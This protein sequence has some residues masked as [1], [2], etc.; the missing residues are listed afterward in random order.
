MPGIA[1]MLISLGLAAFCRRRNHH[2]YGG[3]KDDSSNQWDQNHHDRFWNFHWNLTGFL[4]YEDFVKGISKWLKTLSYISSALSRVYAFT[5]RCAT[6]QSI[7]PLCH[8]WWKPEESRNKGLWRRCWPLIIKNGRKKLSFWDGIEV[9]DMETG[10]SPQ[11][12]PL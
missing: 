2:R 9:I 5:A 12:L 8:G 10:L 3:S 7:I 11:L 4:D 6:T 1:D